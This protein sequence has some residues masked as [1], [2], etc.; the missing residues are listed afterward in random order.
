MN[1]FWLQL[2]QPLS[3]LSPLSSLTLSSVAPTFTVITVP[4]R[5]RG[6]EAGV[7]A[8]NVPK[9]ECLCILSN[10]LVVLQRDVLESE[11][12]KPGLS[13][14]IPLLWHHDLW[15]GLCPAV[16]V[17]HVVQHGIMIL[18]LTFNRGS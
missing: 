3:L 15:K 7:E 12:P 10:F 5:F 9:C 11:I 4:R 6:M 16:G 18:L 14:R 8:D 13:H 1:S 17:K 2:Q